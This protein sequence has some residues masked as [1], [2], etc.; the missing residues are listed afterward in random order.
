MIVVSI[1]VNIESV[2]QKCPT[3]I[4][5]YMCGLFNFNVFFDVEVFQ[6]AVR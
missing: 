5:C 4:S 2:L 6:M 3:R 1:G